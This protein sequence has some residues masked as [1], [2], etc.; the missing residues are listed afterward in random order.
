M[1]R[2][3]KKVIRMH[4]ITPPKIELKFLDVLAA[5]I[6]RA[7]C[8]PWRWKQQALLKCRQTFTRLHGTIIQK[9]IIFNIKV[10]F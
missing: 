6:I 1:L 2:K 10:N 4:M 5:S 9:T 8:G 7:M 3:L